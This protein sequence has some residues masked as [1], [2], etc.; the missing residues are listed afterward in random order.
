MEASQ[1]Q[2]RKNLAD[3]Q[4]WLTEHHGF[5]LMPTICEGI[6]YVASAFFAEGP[7]LRYS[8]PSP[9]LAPVFPTYGD[10]MRRPTMG[11]A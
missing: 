6:E 8:F 11:T 1:E 2:F 5:T 7:A 3:V 4:N 10:L 9:R